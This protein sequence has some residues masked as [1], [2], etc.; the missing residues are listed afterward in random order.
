MT[1]LLYP[2]AEA[3]EQLGGIGR[4]TLYQLF[5]DGK[6]TPTKLGRR[7]FV[8]SDEL[9]RYVSSLKAQQPEARKAG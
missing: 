5:K 3:R 7:V 2:E 1:R 9:E 6:L 4:S 8:S